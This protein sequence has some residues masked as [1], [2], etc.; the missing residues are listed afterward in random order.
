MY[1]YLYSTYVK[2]LQRPEE[3]FRSP[4]SG[5]KAGCELSYRC[6]ELNLGSPREQPMLL[7]TKQCLHSL[8][9]S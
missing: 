4:G 3:D 7:T 6:L 9:G 2:C 5:V 1:I 8:K